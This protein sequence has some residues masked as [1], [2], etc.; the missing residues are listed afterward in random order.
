[1]YKHSHSKHPSLFAWYF[2][3]HSSKLAKDRGIKLLMRFTNYKIE[4]SFIIER[5]KYG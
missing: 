1:M 3:N 4:F 2:L 5:V